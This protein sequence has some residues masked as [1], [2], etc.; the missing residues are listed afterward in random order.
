MAAILNCPPQM[1]FQPNYVYPVI[2]SFFKAKMP[3]KDH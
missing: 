2:G 1:V 3:P